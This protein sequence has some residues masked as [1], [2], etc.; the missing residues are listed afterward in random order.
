MTPDNP[1][2]IFTRDIYPKIYHLPGSKL[3]NLK[4]RRI[5]EHEL[6]KFTKSP[7]SGEVIIVS[8]KLDGSGVGV[9]KK[10]GKILAITK[11]GYLCSTAKHYQHRLFHLWVDQR[12]T[13]FD[14]FLNEGEY[15]CGE[16][17]AQAHG[18]FY[19]LND[20]SPFVVFDLFRDNWVVS[21]T[22]LRDRCAYAGLTM[23]PILYWTTEPISVSL[24]MERLGRCGHYGAIDLAEG[25]VWRRE[26]N[27]TCNHILAKYVRP[28][29]KVGQYLEIETGKEA[30][31]NVRPEDLI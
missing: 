10:N 24:A 18:T 19:A 31:W 16:W 28:E 3:A 1:N 7:D 9:Y 12:K 23:V 25:A 27:G 5:A 2:R 8:E 26:L 6:E 4:D 20:R 11:A 13:Q 15:V 21:Y 29:V 14:Q 22:E 17:L 30:V